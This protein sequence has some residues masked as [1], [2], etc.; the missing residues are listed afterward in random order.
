VTAQ[1]DVL[2][3]NISYQITGL[4]PFTDRP[5]ATIGNDWGVVKKMLTP[6]QIT[7]YKQIA[8]D[9][10]KKFFDEGWRGLFGIDVVL[11]EK[12]GRLYLLEINAR[13]AASTTYESQLQNAGRGTRDEG[14]EITTFEAHLASLLNLN[15]NKYSLILI[16]DGAQIIQRVTKDIPTLSV[17]KG[18]EMDFSYILYNNT[19]PNSDLLRIQTPYTIIRKHNEL[20][21]NGRTLIDFVIA[22]KDGK[23]WNMPRGGII[24]I[25]NSKILLLER[26]K[27][28]KN[29]FALPGG[30]QEEGENIK[31]TAIREG[32]EETGLEFSLQDIEPIHIDNN[33]RDEYYF[34]SKDISGTPQL[35]EEESG[36]N[37]P[38]NSYK[39]VWVNLDELD[40]I[41]LIPEE[42]KRKILQGNNGTI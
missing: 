42:I 31:D 24:F 20:N 28:G 10:G 17:N 6:E 37:T 25:K 21:R 36:R 8:Q 14:R 32:V 41:N 29:F 11:D 18:M 33:G 15:L 30:T 3:G 34:F 19:K 35:G 13:Q 1:G 9:V 27:F 39:L 26:H 38:Q 7:Y 5:F 2:I 16:D 12:T 40:E 22:I 4:E 23:T